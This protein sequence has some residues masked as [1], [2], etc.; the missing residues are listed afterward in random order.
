MSCGERFCGGNE[1]PSA[2][3]SDIIDEKGVKFL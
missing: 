3:S 2:A 1:R